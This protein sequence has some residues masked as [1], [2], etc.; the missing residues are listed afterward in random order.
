MGFL[1][2]QLSEAAESI[3]AFYAGMQGRHE[4]RDGSSCG[5]IQLQRRKAADMQ[6]HKAVA[7]GFDESP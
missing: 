5:R 6:P 7:A 4:L 3:V 2:K 1:Q